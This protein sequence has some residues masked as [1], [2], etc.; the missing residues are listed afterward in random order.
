MNR[1]INRIY[2][3]IPI[4]KTIPG[5]N[6]Q[7]H[8]S[9]WKKLG[10]KPNLKWYKSYASINGNESPEYITEIDYYNKVELILNNRTF[11]EAYCDKNFYHKYLNNTLLPK[12]YLRNIQ[13]VYYSQKYETLSAINDIDAVISGS[14]MQIIIKKTIDSGGG[15]SIDLF[16][17]NGKHWRNSGG[18]LL[19]FDYLERVFGKNFIL[20][21]YIKQHPYFSKFNSSSLNTVRLFTYRSVK[22]NE[23]I[24]LQAVLR[25]GLPGS[26][27]DNQASGGVSC[28]IN[29]HGKLNKFVINKKGERF[30]VFNQVSFNELE[31]VVKFD[32]IVSHG[33]EIAKKFH[34]HRLLGF[35]FCVDEMGEV[36]LIE[37]NNRNNEINFFQMNNG[38][39]FREYTNEIIEFCSKNKKTVCFDFEI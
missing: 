12:I 16:V 32:E 37:I 21:E 11:S 14:E 29:S 2:N 26:I 36:K 5:E 19:T 10:S 23:I 20:Q 35:D 9:I 7:R 24:P 4:K 8:I 22:T 34:Y 30:D 27:V 28:G 39:L 25:I 17:K 3:S 31:A 38:P 18:H 33:L 1:K 15:R 13:G 6:I